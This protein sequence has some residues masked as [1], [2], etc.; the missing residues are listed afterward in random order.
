VIA[1]EVG[2]L[3]LGSNSHSQSGIMIAQWHPAELQKLS[4]GRLLFTPDQIQKL[5][6]GALILT[7]GLTGAE[8]LKRSPYPRSFSLS[9]FMDS[10]GTN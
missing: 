8:S 1:H 4:M 2:H 5:R 6:D 10:P 3:L 9:Q 7:V